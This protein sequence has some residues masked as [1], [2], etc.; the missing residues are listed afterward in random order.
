MFEYHASG[1]NVEQGLAEF[2]FVGWDVV[3]G[4]GWGAVMPRTHLGHVASIILSASGIVSVALLTATFVSN[5]ELDAS[6]LGD[7]SVVAM[8]DAMIGESKTKPARTRAARRFKN[9]RAQIDHFT[10]TEERVANMKVIHADLTVLKTALS[11][12]VAKIEADQRDMGKLVKELHKKLC[13][14]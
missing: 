1:L 13:V 10:T 11:A 12:R 2:L 3:S 5:S 4:L 6:E 9:L 14:V 8:T 7:R